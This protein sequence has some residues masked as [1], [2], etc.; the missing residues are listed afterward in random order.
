MRSS[1]SRFR[2]QIRRILMATISITGLLASAAFTKLG[3]EGPFPGFKGATGW[4]NS[5]PLSSE[6]LRGKVVLVDFWTYSCINCLRSLPYVKAWNEKY[7]DRGLVVVGVHTPEFDFEKERAN[8]EKRTRKLGITYPVAMDNNYKIWNAFKNEY[9]PAHY[10]IDAKGRIR[11]H[12]FGEG[13]YEES[14]RWIQQLLDE[15][16]QQAKTTNKSTQT[17]AASVKA[18][19]EQAAA[20]KMAGR[21]SPETYLGTQRAQRFSSSESLAAGVAKQYTT[22]K[23]L[24]LNSWALSG[25][26]NVAPQSARLIKTPGAISYTFRAR[27]VHLVLGSRDS[28]RTI[29]FRVTVDGK[30]PGNSAGVDVKP[31]GTGIVKDHR[32]YQLVRLQDGL[33]KVHTF[34]IEFLDPGVQAYAFTFG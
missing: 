27:D 30:A 23:K 9:W 20:S 10:L 26:W 15:A 25:V 11:Y 7:K 22:P 3:D 16:D 19:G 21:I 14:E 31:D 34:R 13:K 4:I 32:L 17:I 1:D 18:I 8:I 6:S 28:T 2:A 24:E 12:H 5:E 33:G 29:R